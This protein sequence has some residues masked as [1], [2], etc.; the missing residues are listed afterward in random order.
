MRM[1]FLDIDFE[2]VKN[3]SIGTLAALLANEYWFK[4][5]QCAGFGQPVR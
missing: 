2:G 4:F 3:L 5:W 1:P